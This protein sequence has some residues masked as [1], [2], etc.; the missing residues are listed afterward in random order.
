MQK[1]YTIIDLTGDELA[2]F[3]PTQPPAV[4][5][6]QFG[7]LGSGLNAYG[8]PTFSCMSFCVAALPDNTIISMI[9]YYDFP[10]DGEG[11]RMFFFDFIE[12]LPDYKRQGI[13]AALA[14]HYSNLCRRLGVQQSGTP[15]KTDEGR[16]FAQSRRRAAQL[17]I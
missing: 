2:T 1:S 11:R 8:N 13:G 7:L 12:T 17:N 16:A 3:S 10:P 9:G 5:G 14:D 6:R 4:L 15:P